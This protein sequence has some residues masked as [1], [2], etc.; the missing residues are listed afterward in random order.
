MDLTDPAN[1]LNPCSS[2]FFVTTSGYLIARLAG[3]SAERTYAVTMGN[4]LPGL[5]VLL[6]GTSTAAGIA[7]R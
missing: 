4:I 5:F 1:G 6:K 7:R 2:E 3:D